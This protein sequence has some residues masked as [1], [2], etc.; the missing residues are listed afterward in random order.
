MKA[1]IAFV[2]F[3]FLFSLSLYGASSVWKATKGGQTLYVGGTIHILRSGDFPLPPEFDRAFARSDA[4]VFETDLQ[5]TLS[6]PFAT[7]MARHMLLPDR[8]NLAGVLKP[9]TYA[10]MQEY[11]SS[12]GEDI[13]RYE[14]LRPWAA[15]TMMAQKRLAQ[16][17]IDE[18]GVDAYYARRALAERKETRFLETP[19]EQLALIVR[20]GE[21]EEDELI[22]Q[23]IHEMR[24]LSESVEWLVCEWREG[25]TKRIEGELVDAMKAQSPNMYR[26]ILEKR[27]RAWLPRLTEWSKEGK[28]LFILVGTMHLL[29]DDG[30]LRGLEK[31]GYSITPL[32]EE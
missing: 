12:Q 18:S 16:E 5:S 2:S 20:M 31:E 21:G 15:A 10:A 3:L 11:L 6:A 24:S 29:G 4:V 9:S 19:A 13:R 14:R 26:E 23:T 27:N 17:G 25:K 1:L 8:E 7:E 30:L 28:T 22:L 32:A